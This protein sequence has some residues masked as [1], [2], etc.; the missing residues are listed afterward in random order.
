MTMRTV[1]QAGLD[2]IKEFEGCKLQAYLD[3]GGV[4]TIGVGHTGPEVKKGLV[5]TQAQ[6]DAALA[7]DLKTACEA[8]DRAVPG[9]TD[10]RFAACV[11]FTFNVGVAAFRSS[12]LLK[13]MLAKD[14]DGA[15]GQFGRW[16]KD[17]GKVIPGLVRRRAAEAVL[18]AKG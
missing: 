7:S 3:T 12:T 5:W 2:L 17:N 13:L 15:V 16:V 11:A 8:V 10:N 4:W 6:A 18:F 9:L 1:N 14:W